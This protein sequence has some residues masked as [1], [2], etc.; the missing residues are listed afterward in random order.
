M[1][2]FLKA[3]RVRTDLL[4]CGQKFYNQIVLIQSRARL[5]IALYDKTAKD[6]LVRLDEN[7]VQVVMRL[8]ENK[9]LLKKYPEFKK[10]LNTLNSSHKLKAIRD[11][12][13]S[14]KIQHTL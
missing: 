3:V 11:I 2:N 9:N 5:Q 10:A 14:Y 1:Q 13:D 12:M 6:I 8:A 7:L 4:L